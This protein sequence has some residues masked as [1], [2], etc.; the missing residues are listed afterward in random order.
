[1]RMLPVF[2]IHRHT[3]G[4]DGSMHARP[5]E[6]LRDL[7]DENSILSNS[8]SS[9]VEFVIRDNWL[10]GLF[11]RFILLDGSNND[12]KAKQKNSRGNKDKNNTAP[13]PISRYVTMLYGRSKYQC[14]PAHYSSFR[15]RTYPKLFRE[16]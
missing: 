2:P 12:G 13:P 14:N 1:M 5:H 3:D 11:S 16:F 10:F 8:V 9:S 7:R 6:L 4:M 15:A